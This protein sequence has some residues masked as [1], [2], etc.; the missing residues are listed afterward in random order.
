MPADHIR[1]AHKKKLP[2]VMAELLT[3]AGS[4]TP[5]QL[6]LQ[7]IISRAMQRISPGSFTASFNWQSYQLADAFVALTAWE[8]HLMSY[9]FDAPRERIHVVPNGV[10]AEFFNSPPAV[11]GQWL[12]CTAI[13]TERKR[14]LELGEAAVAAQTP[15]WVIGKAYAESDPYAQNFFALARRHPQILRYE[16]AVADR[17]ELARIYRAARGFVLLSAQES[18]SLSA[19]E[20]A[21]CECPLLLSDLPWAHSS[22]SQAATYCPIT[23][24]VQTTAKALR[25][26]YEAAPKMPVP[27]KPPT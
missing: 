24:S 20:A 22:F 13:I 11:R 1:L 10:E 14:V 26:F 19:L 18:L 2:V 3:G 4:R 12:V 6:R 9:L 23:S 16:G 8:A 21:A 25:D 5:S 27:P 7:K 15:L 17:S